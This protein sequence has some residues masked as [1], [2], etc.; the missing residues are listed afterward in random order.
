M[1]AT[2]LPT[3]TNPATHEGFRRATGLPPDGLRCSSFFS[4][5][6]PTGFNVTLFLEGMTS[7]SNNLSGL[8]CV[9]IHLNRNNT[10]GD[11]ILPPVYHACV[12]GPSSSRSSTTTT[13]RNTSP[14]PSADA[15]PASWKEMCCVWPASTPPAALQTGGML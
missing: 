13:P 10:I 15:P 2:L 6:F 9:A 3:V 14:P 1:C 12:A 7:W 4:N 5:C 11:V 8:V